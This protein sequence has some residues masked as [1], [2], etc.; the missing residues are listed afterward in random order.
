M[1]IRSKS[2]KVNEKKTKGKAILRNS[3]VNAN[4]KKDN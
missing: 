3:N 2:Y 4:N 1:E